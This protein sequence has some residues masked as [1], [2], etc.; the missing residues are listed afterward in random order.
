MFELLRNNLSLLVFLFTFYAFAGWCLEVLYYFKTEKRFVNRGFL[1]GPFCPIYGACIVLLV[2]TLDKFRDN[3][4]LLFFM[5][6]FITSLIE[7][8]TGFVLEKLFNDK[9][10]D[11]TEDPL[12]IHGR[13]CLLYSLFW[14]VGQVII[15]VFVNP[16]V[17]NFIVSSPLFKSYSAP[18]AACFIVL[19][20]M[21]DLTYTLSMMDTPEKP[22]FLVAASNFK[23]TKGKLYGLNFSEVLRNIKNKFRKF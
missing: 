9:W 8:I 19:Y 11:Y 1:K 10:W 20:F 12:N 17:V 7:Y 13:V 23:F 4:P 15:I 18:A 6:F 5:S 3:I 14:A 21:A 2:Y 22:Q 16:K